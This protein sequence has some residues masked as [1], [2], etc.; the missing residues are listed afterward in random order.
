[1]GGEKGGVL[2]LEQVRYP[3]DLQGAESSASC[4]G[5]AVTQESGCWQDQRDSWVSDRGPQSHSL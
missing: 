4:P 5:R 2:V 3:E 1:M